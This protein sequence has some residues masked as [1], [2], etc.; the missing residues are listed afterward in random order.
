M[1]FAACI[2]ARLPEGDAAAGHGAISL[3]WA[4][5]TAITTENGRASG[6][7]ARCRFSGRELRVRAT[8]G[9]V[10]VALRKRDG[11]FDTTPEPD[12]PLEIGDVLIA[13]GTEPELQAL[14]DMFAPR[15]PVGG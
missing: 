9:A 12:V 8:T 7:V 4:A 13:I 5:V 11:T 3:N 2:N 15:E 14:E 10:I 6:V 1:R